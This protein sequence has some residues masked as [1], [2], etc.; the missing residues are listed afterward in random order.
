MKER[1]IHS[2][3]FIW[4]LQTRSSPHLP[5]RHSVSCLLACDPTTLSSVLKFT[6]PLISL[7]FVSSYLNCCN[8]VPCCFSS[9]LISLMPFILPE[10]GE[11]SFDLSC[12]HLHLPYLHCSDVILGFNFLLSYNNSAE[13]LTLIIICG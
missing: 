12:G 13:A 11:Y 9:C 3:W 1:R 7:S 6:F 10:K 4:C 8:Y 5:L 2:F